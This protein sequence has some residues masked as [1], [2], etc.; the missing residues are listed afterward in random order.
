M[1]I[2]ELLISCVL[3]LKRKWRNL[4]I[5]LKNAAGIGTIGRMAT[6]TS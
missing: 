6:G 3:G 5:I 2:K 4:M 1:N